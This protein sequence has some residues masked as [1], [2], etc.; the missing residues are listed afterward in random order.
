MCKWDTKRGQGGGNRD[1]IC[2][3]A[4]KSHQRQLFAS[5]NVFLEIGP[6]GFPLEIVFFPCSSSVFALLTGQVL[7]RPSV[8]GFS[9]D[10]RQMQHTAAHPLNIGMRERVRPA[11][12]VAGSSSS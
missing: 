10:S 4:L 7:T 6:S 9:E 11:C 2:S 5:P 3:D 8:L 1:F 12:H